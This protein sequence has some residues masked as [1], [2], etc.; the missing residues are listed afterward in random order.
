MILH[1][2]IF[3][4]HSFFE[5]N[6]FNRLRCIQDVL[7]F[8][9]II[10]ITK[11]FYGQQYLLTQV[12]YEILSYLND[13]STFCHWITILRFKCNNSCAVFLINKNYI[14][15]WPF[16]IT[17]WEHVK[18]GSDGLKDYSVA[19]NRQNFS[20]FNKHVSFLFCETFFWPGIIFCVGFLLFWL[21]IISR[22]L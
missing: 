2:V 20:S 12:L 15:E 19:K 10:Y 18:Y 11:V 1:N 7:F 13:E 22:S 6:K 21:T 9:T 16:V 14:P 5:F 8:F 3:R 4:L 17:G